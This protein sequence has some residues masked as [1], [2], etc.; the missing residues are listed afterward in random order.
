MSNRRQ[1][2]LPGA[3]L[4][5][6]DRRAALRFAINPQTTSHLVA[7]V[8]EAFW[9]AYVADISTRGIALQV[10]RKFEPGR[11]VLLELA[12]GVRIFSL[13]LLMQ[14]RHVHQESEGVWMIGG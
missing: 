9:P 8:G 12:N 13:A 7:A 3:S 11:S 10:R 6:L 5:W 4:S 1:A 2:T 14:I